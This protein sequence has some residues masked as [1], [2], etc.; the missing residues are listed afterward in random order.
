MNSCGMQLSE[1]RLCVRPRIAS[2]Y[3]SQ[4]IHPIPNKWDNSYPY[5]E[6]DEDLLGQQ[7]CQFL[8]RF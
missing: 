6:R 4:I 3:R 2:L 1:S 7:A 8:G 5:Y